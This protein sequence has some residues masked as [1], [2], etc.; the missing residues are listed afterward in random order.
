[1]A[2][3]RLQNTSDFKEVIKKYAYQFYCN[4]KAPQQLQFPRKQTFFDLFSV[5]N[6]Q[7]S[8]EKWQ[9]TYCV[10]FLC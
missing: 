10:L 9:I 3:F 7:N 2:M 8:L 6:A 1:M 5:A 4:G